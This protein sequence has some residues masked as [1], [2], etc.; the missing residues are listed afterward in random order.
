[1]NNI[2]ELKSVVKEHSIFVNCDDLCG[3]DSVLELIKNNG[4]NILDFEFANN[5]SHI[6]QKHV[7][8]VVGGMSCESQVSYSSANGIANAIKKLGYRLT[9]I[10][11]GQD[12]A[13][14]LFRLRPDIVFN[15]L[16]GTYGEDGCL[17]GVL[18][19][20]KIP[21]TGS[22]LLASALAM[23]KKMSQKIFQKNNIPTIPYKIVHKNHGIIEDP[24]A[25]PYVIKPLAQGSSIGV[26]IIMENDEFRF[27]EYEFLYG[28]EI[29]IEKYIKGREFQV[30]ILDGKALGLLEIEFIN[31]K[32]FYDYEA[33]YT[34]GFTN[35]N[36]FPN[37]PDKIYH[38][39]L[40]LSELAYNAIGCRAIARAEFIYD[41]QVNQL[42][43]L[44]INT[45]P[46]MT[47]MSICPEI[48]ASI[49]ISF[50]QLIEKILLSA[51]FE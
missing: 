11:M 20:L 4:R 36:L 46:G 34:P 43:I 19:I 39:L 29:I 15:G 48:A 25:R 32:L 49:S 24:M 47:P 44:E 6:L 41:E 2:D 16:Y 8:L 40:R 38:E 13:N 10:D 30:A 5:N 21:Y 50:D 18:N 37:L 9:L 28:D 26:H 35:H 1:M 31:G 42:Y 27:S 22:G 33:K 14:V 23:N 51:A 12:I 17:Q 7:A 3:Y 45:L